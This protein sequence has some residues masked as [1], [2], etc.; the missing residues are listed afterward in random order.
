MSASE[1][2]KASWKNFLSIFKFLGGEN[3]AREKTKTPGKPG[4][5][6]SGQ[7]VV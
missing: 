4:K 3:S 2:S 1:E 7:M 5:H 6:K